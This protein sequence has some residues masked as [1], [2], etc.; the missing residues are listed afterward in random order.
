MSNN[1]L[2]DLNELVNE[3]KTTKSLTGLMYPP[4]EATAP[5]KE[6]T[7]TEDNIDDFI[8]RKSSVLIQQGV[9]TMEKLKSSVQSGA[10]A[11]T[12]EAYSKLMGS[13]ASSIE[14]LNKINLQKRKERAAKELKQMDIDTSKKLLDKYDHPTIQ[15]QTN[16]LVASREEIMKA[17]LGQA[18]EIVE[19]PV[20]RPDIID[21]PSR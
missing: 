6:E 19:Q 15:N 7:I 5:T 21:I 14:I 16:I 11:E 2:D 20:D 18:N 10:N 17:L 9:D 1:E 12:I 8:F 4:E 3:L 13:V